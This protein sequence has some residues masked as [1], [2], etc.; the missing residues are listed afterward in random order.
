MLA[1]AQ[2]EQRHHGRF[3]VLRGVAFEDLGD[4]LLV[5]GVEFEGNRR[6]IGGSVAMLYIQVRILGFG[7]H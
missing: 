2:I 5:Y 7:G 6:V 3:F 1:L 4:E